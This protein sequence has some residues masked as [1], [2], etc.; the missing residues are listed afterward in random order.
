MGPSVTVISDDSGPEN[1]HLEEDP[2]LH[3]SMEVRLLP[4]LENHRD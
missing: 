1:L 2:H 3:L 4:G